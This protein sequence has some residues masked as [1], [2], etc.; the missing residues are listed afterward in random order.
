MSE[1]DAEVAE[2]SDEGCCLLLSIDV[3][4]FSVSNGEPDNF[5]PLILYGRLK[6][7]EAPDCLSLEGD[8]LTAH[9]TSLGDGAS[10]LRVNE[11]QAIVQDEGVGGIALNTEAAQQRRCEGGVKV[12]RL[13]RAQNLQSPHLIL[14]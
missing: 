5:V 2:E 4:M 14:S 12:S 13:T 6:F 8:K 11:R 10:L 3:D 7:K 1:F 9:G